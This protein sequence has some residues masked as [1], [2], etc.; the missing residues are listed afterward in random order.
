MSISIH[1]EAHPKYAFPTQL[2]LAS[3]KSLRL[4]N[5]PLDTVFHFYCKQGN[6]KFF[7]RT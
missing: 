1:D 7:D 6:F 2:I 5:L 4:E 3:R